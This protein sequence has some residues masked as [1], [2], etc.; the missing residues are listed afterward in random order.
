MFYLWILDELCTLVR[1]TA[2]PYEWGIPASRI[3]SFT[4]M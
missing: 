2:Q 1:S 4:A 3:G